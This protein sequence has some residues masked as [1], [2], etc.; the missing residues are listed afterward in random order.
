LRSNPDSGLTIR[1]E[2]LK[3]EERLKIIRNKMVRDLESQGVNP[4]YLSEM[5]NV[6]VGKILRR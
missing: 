5:K 6:D 2:L 3:E 4:K 1:E